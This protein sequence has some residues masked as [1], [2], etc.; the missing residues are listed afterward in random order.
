MSCA[1]ALA[2][3]EGWGA[4]GQVGSH[5]CCTLFI[6]LML[7]A[8]YMESFTTANLDLMIYLDYIHSGGPNDI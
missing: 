4:E 2:D 3:L 5:L 1:A 8:K 7:K 6:N